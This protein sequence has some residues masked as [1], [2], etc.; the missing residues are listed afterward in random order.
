MP[1]AI[2]HVDMDAFYASVEQRDKPELRGKPVIVGADPQERGVVAACS[3]GARHFGVHSAMPSRTAYRLCPQGIFLRPDM[4]K[5]KSVSRQVMTVLQSF[6]PLV[7]P[8]SIDEAFLDVSGTAKRLAEAKTVAQRIKAE[9]RKQTGLTASVGVAPNKFLAKLASDLNKPDG[10]T[11]ITEEEKLQVLA[12]LPVSKVL[13]VGKVTERRL[14]ELG[15][16]TIGDLQKF[17]LDELRRRLGNVAGLLH[18]L[19]LGEDDRE[20]VTDEGTKSISSE[21]TFDR[22]TSNLDQIKRCLLEQ[23]EDVGASLRRE[24]LAARTVQLKLRYADFT[25]L[26]RRKTLLKPTQ[27]GMMLYQVAERLLSAERIQGKR[28]RLIGVGGTNLVR[29]EMQGD[30]FDRK[31]EK[32]ARLAKAVDGLR[33]KLGPGAIKRGSSIS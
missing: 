20:V 3:Y 7:Q 28:I 1:R 12:P 16:R 14:Q 24:Q 9:I 17:P 25:T 18:A 19:A 31:D 8:I 4:E 32:R 33:E 30:L 23:A 10:L 21:N 6:T 15:I 13:D 22:D 2:L 27:D 26:T 5:Y 29:P 11:I